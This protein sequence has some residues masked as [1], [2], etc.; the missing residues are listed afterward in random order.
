MWISDGECRSPRPWRQ[1][2]WPKHVLRTIYPP[3]GAFALIFSSELLG[4]WD[5]CLM[6]V[7]GTIF[8]IGLG[9]VI[10][11]LHPKRSYPTFWV[12]LDGCGKNCDGR[13]ADND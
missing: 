6:Q 5:K 1:R 2:L 10:N 11:N 8:V 12:G 13:M 4:W 9:I 3:G 7:V